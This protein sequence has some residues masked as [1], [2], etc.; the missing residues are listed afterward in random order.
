MS[1]KCIVHLEFGY[2]HD[3]TGVEKKA[4]LKPVLGVLKFFFPKK[5]STF[6]AL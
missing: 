5:D 1:V 2:R 6:N 4:H 3:I